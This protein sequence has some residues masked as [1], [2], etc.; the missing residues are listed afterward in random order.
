MNN[1][2]NKALLNITDEIFSRLAPEGSFLRD[3]LDASN[4][5]DENNN[6]TSLAHYNMRLAVSK[7]LQ[8]IE[9]DDAET[10]PLIK[11]LTTRSK[12]LNN[13]DVVQGFKSAEIVLKKALPISRANH[14]SVQFRSFT[15]N[16]SSKLHNEGSVAVLPYQSILRNSSNYQ[17]NNSVGL[18]EILTKSGTKVINFVDPDLFPAL[19]QKDSVLHHMLQNI[20][21]YS[22]EK[23]IEYSVIAGLKAQLSDINDWPDYSHIKVLLNKPLGSVKGDSINKALLDYERLLY[24]TRSDKSLNQLSSTF[25]QYLCTYGF[26]APSLYV[27]KSRFKTNFNSVGNLNF[28]PSYTIMTT[29]DNYK[30]DG[31]KLASVLPTDSVCEHCFAQ[32]EKKAKHE[33]AQASDITKL[34]ELLI[35]IEQG[36]YTDARLFLARKPENLRRYYI[37]NGFKKIEEIIINT[38]TDEKI[39]RLT[40]IKDFLKLCNVPT[41]NGKLI[42][43][44]DSEITSQE[45]LQTLSVNSYSK[46]NGKKKAVSYKFNLSKLKGLLKPSG[47]LATALNELRMAS[48]SSEIPSSKLSNIELALGFVVN[49][50]ENDLIKHVLTTPISELTRRDFRVGFSQLEDIIDKQDINVK[51]SR[52]QALRTFL[53]Q[54]AG[55]INGQIEIKNS[56]FSSRFKAADENNAPKLIEPVDESG[57]ILPSPVLEKHLSLDELKK[58]VREY[59]TQ[60]INQILDACKSE[61]SN[62]KKLVTC[63]STYTAIDQEGNYSYEMPHE[64]SSIVLENQQSDGSRLKRTRILPIRE[65][66]G[67]EVLIGAYV[68]HQ[69]SS[70]LESRTYCLDK[71]KLIPDY[72]HHWFHNTGTGMKDFFW[73]SV[74]LPKNILLVCF[75]RLM[76]RTTWNKDV[77]A[78]LERSDLPD[79]LPEGPFTI[80]GYKDKVGKNTYLV[81]IEPHEKEIRDVISFLIQHYDNM[82]S[83][84]LKPESLWDTPD[85]SKLSFLSATAI[86]NFRKHYTLPFFRMEILAKHQINLRKG[87]DGDVIKSQMERNHSSLRVTSSY[88]AHP[89]S[90]LEY[91]ANNADFQRRFETTVQFR[92]KEELLKKYGFDPKNIDTDLIIA[93][94]D[95]DEKLPEWF[96]LPDGSSCTDIFASV[97]KSKKDNICRGRKCHAGEGCDFN[98]VEIGVEEFVYTLRNQV[99]YISRGEALL[100]KHGQE[101][102]DE[103]IA[104]DMRFTFGLVKYVELANSALFKEAKGRLADAY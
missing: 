14:Y 96:L 91:E 32:L 1:K 45:K 72:V 79:T 51:C 43:E 80:S 21:I 69:V 36:N 93:P 71:Q 26:T 89:I 87:I 16:F 100:D 34:L 25:R 57:E 103:F 104:P 86:D 3:C 15:K 30:I 10:M 50:K 76:L 27:E 59:L 85:S 64:V 92:H 37:T 19:F 7:L 90:K 101:Y 78:I 28:R 63:F 20:E 58:E 82:V 40:I 73:C 29:D 60:P 11:L 13:K 55:K 31:F 53:S 46:T 95:T 66:Y 67:S 47:T 49:T 38:F 22:K 42:S 81:K 35:I 74:F 8:V 41:K 33:P 18:F 83:Y 99:Y 52:S 56:G 97:D 88:L 39:K 61:I 102:F 12:R 5:D 75:I 54:H 98:I 48:S 70:G 24:T 23:R 2:R 62:Y 94:G 84:G 68:R 44:I 77:V 6:S 9:S 4:W 65:Q 17:K